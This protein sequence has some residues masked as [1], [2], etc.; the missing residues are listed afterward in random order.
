MNVS[1]RNFLAKVAAVPVV[2]LTVSD[3]LT[4]LLHPGR[5]IFI[6]ASGAD[7]TYEFYGRSHVVT[8]LDQQYDMNELIRQMIDCQKMYSYPEFTPRVK[9]S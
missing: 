9:A 1:R 8:Y 5:R 6:P 4:E 3:A 7:W 2:T